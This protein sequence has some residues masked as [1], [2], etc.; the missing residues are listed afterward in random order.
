MQFRSKLNQK[1]QEHFRHCSWDG[2]GFVVG[3][4]AGDVGFVVVVGDA[5]G[6]RGSG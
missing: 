6:R 1:K 3:N 4:V 5:V 2:V